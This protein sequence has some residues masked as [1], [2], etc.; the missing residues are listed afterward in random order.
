L[1]TDELASRMNEIRECEAKLAELKKSRVSWLFDCAAVVSEIESLLEQL[2]S[3][4]PDK[5]MQYTVR[6]IPERR[7]CLWR[8]SG[9][10]EI[11]GDPFQWPSIYSSNKGQIDSKFRVYQSVIAAEEQKYTKAE[12]LI[13]PGQVFDI[14]R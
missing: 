11:Y 4:L 12:D 1:S 14:P 2:K 10:E 13:Y 6:M 7:D 3:H 5:P 8:I 9:Y